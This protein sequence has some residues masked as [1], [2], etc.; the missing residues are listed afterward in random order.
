MGG[1]I[2]PIIAIVCVFSVPIIAILVHHQRKMAELIHRN[3]SQAIQPSAEVQA[4]RHE[5]GELRQLL[6]QQTI[7]LDDLRNRLPVTR[8]EQEVSDRFS[9]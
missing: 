6:H 7:T 9:A 3:H 1:A 4:L 5:I 2:I 8:T